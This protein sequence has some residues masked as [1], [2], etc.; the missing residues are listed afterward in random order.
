MTITLATL[1]QATEQ[2]IFNQVVTHLAKQR[3]GARL[4]DKG[5]AYRGEG[6]SMC[7][8]GCL[9]ADSEYDPKMDAIGGPTAWDSLVSQGFAPPQHEHFILELQRVHDR[10]FEG[11]EMDV[12]EMNIALHQFYPITVRCDLDTKVLDE[13]IAAL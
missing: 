1:P 8:A 12:H 11:Y 4:Y 2:Q 6:G 3:K 5:C 13:A 10:Y 9:I 7:A